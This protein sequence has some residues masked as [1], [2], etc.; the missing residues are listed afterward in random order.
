MWLFLSAINIK[1]RCIRKKNT[2]DIIESLPDIEEK[3]YSVS[4]NLSMIITN[5]EPDNF[6]YKESFLKSVLL[7]IME[8]KVL[9]I[10]LSKYELFNSVG[11][12][13]HNFEFFEIKNY[14]GFLISPVNSMPNPGLFE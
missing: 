1:N 12:G 3:G 4:W 10:L 2:A 9:K 6:F 8:E 11:R 5:D 13:I 7:N 14:P